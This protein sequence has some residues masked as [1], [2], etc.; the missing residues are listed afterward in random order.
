MVYGMPRWRVYRDQ[1]VVDH[2][3][4]E[5]GKAADES[6]KLGRAPSHPVV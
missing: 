1:L 6:A 4:K 3:L 5:V 2:N